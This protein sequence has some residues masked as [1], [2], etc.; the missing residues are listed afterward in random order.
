[1]D[2]LTRAADHA[3]LQI[4][5]AV[6]AERR[7]H[8]AVLRVEGDQP[9]ARGDVENALVAAAIGPVRDAAAGELSRRRAGARALAQAVRPEHLARFAVEGDDRSAGARGRI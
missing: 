6:L 5:D 7:D 9:V 2:L 3:H 1:M 4:D 8:R